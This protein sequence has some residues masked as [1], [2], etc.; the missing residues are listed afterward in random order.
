MNIV[1]QVEQRVQDEEDNNDLKFSQNVEICSV[2]TN[3][4]KAEYTW[5]TIIIIMHDP[6]HI[7]M[8]FVKQITYE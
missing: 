4:N 1:T 7:N 3:V 6:H 5:E 2:A 8:T